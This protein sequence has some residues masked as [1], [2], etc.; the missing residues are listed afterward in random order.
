M[1]GEKIPFDLMWIIHTF[2][3]RKGGCLCSPVPRL[4]GTSSKSAPFSWRQ[5]ITRVVHVDMGTP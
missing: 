5:A 1:Q 3:D 4:T 2:F